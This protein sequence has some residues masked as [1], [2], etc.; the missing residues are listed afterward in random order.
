MRDMIGGNGGVELDA[1]TQRGAMGHHAGAAAEGIVARD[2]ARRG[3]RVVHRRWRGAGGEIDL[4]ARDG[5][6]V[7]FIEVKHSRG[8]LDAALRLG[9]RQMNRICDSAA[10]FLAGEPRGQLTEVRFDLALVDG[11]GEL[12]VIENAFG[13]A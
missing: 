2:Y 11:R 9:R 12:R 6:R 1:R 7:V 4:I 8:R 10:C 5:D 13:A 3:A